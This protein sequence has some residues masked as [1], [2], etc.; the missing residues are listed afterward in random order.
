MPRKKKRKRTPEEIQRQN[1]TNKWKRL[2]RIILKNFK[3]GDWHLIMK[4][5]EKDR[6]EEYEKAKEQRKEFLAD[7]RKAFKK[8]GIPFKWIAVTE[9]GKKK[10]VLHHHLIIQDFATADLNTVQLVKKLWK[11]GHVQFV[12][13]YE[14]GEYEKLAQYIVKAETK[15]EKGWMSYSRSRNMV[16]PEAKREVKHHKRWRL[17]PQAPEGWYVVKESVVNGTNPFTDRPYQYYTIKKLRGGPD[18]G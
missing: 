10:Q 9:R 3:E 13:L 18:D 1:E 12:S 17:E 15:E 5:R 2:Q 4:Y 8:A 11:Y 6:P 7:M 14:D 16:V